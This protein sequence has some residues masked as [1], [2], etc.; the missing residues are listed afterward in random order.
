MSYKILVVDDEPDNLQLVRRTLRRHYD[1]ITAN[2]ADEAIET[3]KQVNDIEMVLSDHKM[4]GKNGVEL[5]HHCFEHYPDVIRILITAYS[6]VP[7]LVDAINTG[8]IHRYIKKPWTP[9]ELELTV[10]KAFE[11]SKLSR[12]NTRLIT[13]FKDLFSG[14]I[15]AITEALDEKDEFTSGRSKRVCEYAIKIAKEMNLS[16]I[17]ISKIE[18]ASLLHDIGMIG[19]PEY[20]LNKAEKLTDEEYK[21]IQKHVSYGLNIIGS[22]KQLESVVPIIKYHHERYDGSGYPYGIKGEE[23]PIGARIIALADTFDALISTR[24]YRDPMPVDKAIELITSFAGKQLDYNV[25]Q[26]FLKIKDELDL[27]YN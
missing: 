10:E 14:T 7:I 15:S 4:P 3:L 27:D 11:A 8:K 16:D 23:I 26:A 17:E 5:L 9:E 6:E 19:V 2:N 18:V 13:D 12:E 25:V 20:I 21:L 22:I 1:I 24:V